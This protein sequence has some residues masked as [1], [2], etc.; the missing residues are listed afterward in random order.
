MSEETN[1]RTHY[2]SIQGLVVPGDYLSYVRNMGK[3]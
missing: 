3:V 1:G 2:Q